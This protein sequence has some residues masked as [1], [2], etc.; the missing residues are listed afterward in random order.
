M[1]TTIP[2]SLNGLPIGDIFEGQSGVRFVGDAA[3]I[4]MLRDSAQREHDDIV[5]WILKAAEGQRNQQAR[6]TYLENA[7]A[8]HSAKVMKL[9]AAIAWADKILED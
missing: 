4:R 7:V 1:T 2:E 3:A 6:R 8:Q 9:R 5:R